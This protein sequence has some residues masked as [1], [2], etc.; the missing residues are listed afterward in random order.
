MLE[1]HALVHVSKAVRPMALPDIDRLLE[2]ARARNLAKLWAR[3][4]A[5]SIF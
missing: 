2:V 4:R 5:P 3:G 1:L